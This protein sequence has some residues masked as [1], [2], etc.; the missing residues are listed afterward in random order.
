[1]SP[2]GNLPLDVRRPGSFVYMDDT[3]SARGLI[4]A[5]RSVVLIGMKSS[6]GLAPVS[7]PLQVRSE[8]DG[9]L[10]AGTGSELALM[11]RMVF[12]TFRKLGVAPWNGSPAEVWIVPVAAPVGGGAVAAT[13]TLT[14]AGTATAAGTIIVRIAGR[15]IHVPIASGT[16]AANI[17]AAIEAAIDLK[18]SD[19]PVTAG[20]AGAVVT[21]TYVT[22]GVN[23]NGLD[24]TVVQDVP[25]DAVTAA[26]GVTGVG[27]ADVQAALD[28]LMAGDYKAIALGNHAAQDLVD[29]GEHMDEMW[30]PSTKRYR[31]GFVAET[32]TLGTATTL[33]ATPNR[34]ELLVVSFEGGYNTEAEIAAAV[35]AAT[36]TREGPLLNLNDLELPLSGTAEAS[37]YLDSELETA[38]E[39]GVTALKMTTTGG[40]KIV[41]LV[42]T[43]QTQG[44]LDFENLRDFSVPNTMAY[45]A[46]QIDA[47]VRRELQAAQFEQRGVD[48]ELIRDVKSACY[49]TL[50]DIERLGAIHNIDAHAA[51]ITVEPH[52]DAPHRLV[53]QIPVPVVPLAHQADTTLR[54]FVEAPQAAAA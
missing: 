29:L 22:F 12:K 25:G 15:E 24:V 41:R 43:K 36:Q 34:K 7:V 17:A 51:E 32:G 33:S 6:A 11:V 31:F 8:A 54:L 10:Q 26:V 30:G 9:D 45:T 23:G 5:E 19:L 37:N 44:G 52:E 14:A 18:A 21:L 28:S 3:S 47:T 49:N 42:T 16:T 38:I 13:Y 39:G 2:M 27:A 1:M 50:K 48:A 40:V 20:V 35:A 53:I 4:P 46:I